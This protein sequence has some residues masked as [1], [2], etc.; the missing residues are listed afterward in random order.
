MPDRR[1]P[2]A[3]SLALAVAF[4]SIAARARAQ[5]DDLAHELPRRPAT[6]AG[7]A[8]ETIE[9][10]PG[11]RV[12]A[13]AVEPIVADPVAACFDADGRLYVVEMRGYPYPEG[14]APG[15]VAL[16][17]DPDG[18]GR[19]DRRS[20]FVGG[21]SWPTGV[22]PYDGGV[23]IA[24]APEVLYAKDT[25]GDGRADVRRV[26]FDGF[27]TQN[28]QGLLNGLL[29]G[30]DGWI[31]G[32]AGSNGGEVRN[33][34]R[35]DDPPVQVRGR[36]FRFRPEGDG[37]SSALALEAT[38][39][40]VQFGQG[41]DDWGHRFVCSNS[42]QIRQV[43]FPAGVLARNPAL[44]PP[45][46]IAD[47]AADGP[48][49]PVF[50]ISPPEPWRVVR[51]RQRAA[52][53]NFVKRAIPSELHAAG[54]FTSA[55]GVTIYRGSAFPP[56]FRGNAFIGDVGGNLVHRKVL[57]RG[58][59]VLR[60]DRADEGVEFLAS[61]DNWFRPVN[62]ANTPSGTLLVLDMYRE[63]IEH[64]ASIPE[65]IKKHLDLTSGHDRG[66]VW[67][68][69]PAE[70]F[71]RRPGPSLSRATTLELVEHLAGPDAWWR[72]T[73]QRLLIER[74]DPSAIAG[75][76]R[77]VDERPTAL[78]RLHALWT[79]DVLHHLT[80]AILRPTLTD[81]ETALREQAAR[82]AGPR[83]DADPGLLDTLLGL[84]DDP[85]PMVRLATAIALGDV[86]DP[87][88][89]GAL[90]TIA[91]RA[92][93][94]PWTRTAVLSAVAGR[95]A[96]LLA[97][98]ADRPGFVARPEGRAWLGD[99]AT[100]I[101]AEG[102]PEEVGAAI[103]RFG[104]EGVDPALARAVVLGLGLGSRRAGR[105]LLEVAT[106]PV[107]GRLGAI[108]EQA[109]RTARGEGP[110]AERSEAI[111]LL[112]LGPVGLALDVLPDRLDGRE[113]V[114]VQLA[115][116]QAM[117]GLDDPRV[118]PAVVGR[119]RSLGPSVRREAAEVLFARSDRL[120]ALLDALEHGAITS[121]DL[122]PDRRRQLLN[123]PRAAV[124]ERASKLLGDAS[125]ADRGPVLASYRPALDLE[126][127]PARGKQA[128]QAQC[129]TCHRAEG[130]GSAIG[131][132]LETVAGRTPEDLLIHILDPNREVASAY[133]NYSVAT[134]DG[135]LLSGL[136]A[137][138]SAGSITLRRAEGAFDVV[139]RGQIEGIASTGLSLM[140]EGLERVLDPAALADLIAYLR[141]LPTAGTTPAGGR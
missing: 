94:D 47:I 110:P 32:S 98:L 119:W 115:A 28:V 134:A 57:S 81:P 17:E 105:S 87:R 107:A 43:V 50:R 21:L 18:D 71:R 114:A 137:E 12:R 127:D 52:D 61:T 41:F 33:L 67:E 20:E 101:G 2:L 29:W 72:E 132:D 51:T 14:V 96:A 53:P 104:A 117:A 138:E 102:R 95:A 113:P 24:V 118:G 31:Y 131:P 49:G 133:L 27:G 109:G 86:K 129:A 58:G 56:E 22:V 120:G 99:L 48:A 10:R 112:G 25:D 7:A 70:G 75:L 13:A 54:F 3:L 36:D 128:Y 60:A 63:T 80:P 108:F 44:T 84:A 91:G 1:R 40:G 90:A 79:L 73:A 130:Q 116:L 6:E 92:P 97:D 66:R 77:L 35:P 83:A 34:T 93:A 59:S 123:H 62:F 4:V 46:T 68:V 16:L 23:F 106:G 139:P 135:R 121:T 8:V 136:I 5:D 111:G 74:R 26:V 88:A 15:G 76:V 78:G 126:G 9:I 100:L 19:F 11:F 37:S 140:P 39:G 103:D 42:N 85:D 55:T 89:L 69:L 125:K 122:D 124:R 82:L 64:P 30:P 38:T 45:A 65:P 141:A